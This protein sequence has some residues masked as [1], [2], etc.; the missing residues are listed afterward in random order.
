MEWVHMLQACWVLFTHHP[1]WPQRLQWCQMK[2]RSPWLG[3]LVVSG[4]VRINVLLRGSLGSRWFS[5]RVKHQ[6]VTKAQNSESSLQSQLWPGYGLMSACLCVVGPQPETHPFSSVLSY[7]RRWGPPHGAIYV[8]H[9]GQG[10]H[11]Q[12]IP[13]FPEEAW[14]KF[15]WSLKWSLTLGPMGT[16][17]VF[18]FHTCS[19][20]L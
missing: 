8:P 11:G 2:P 20:G 6:T 7:Y 3:L 17:R 18:S 4:G 9:D 13:G 19:H 10:M 12:G 5:Y 1:G 14:Q 16:S 15:S